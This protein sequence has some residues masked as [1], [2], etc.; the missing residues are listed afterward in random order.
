M[1]DTLLD[2]RKNG[3]WG[4]EMIYRDYHYERFFDSF[5]DYY[6]IYFPHNNLLWKR[7]REG[8]VSK[9]GLVID[10]IL[11]PLLPFGVRDENLALKINGDFLS[12]TSERG[13]L[14]PG[15]LEILHYLQPVYKMYIVSNGFREI[16]YA[17]LRSAGIDRF[18]SGVFLSD[19]VGYSKPDVRI[20][21]YVLQKSSTSM[22]E[23]VMIGDNFDADIVGAKESGIDQVWYDLDHVE[24]R[25]FIPTYKIDSLYDLKNFL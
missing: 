22:R 3:K 7:Y 5:E 20:F 17:K 4:M 21:Q 14:L 9:R 16:Q 13:I 25:E 18:F 23:G 8:K 1:D 24:K 15:A 6:N 19:E 12:Y 10:R 11:F 2:T